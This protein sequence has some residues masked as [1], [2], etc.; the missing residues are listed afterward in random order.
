MNRFHLRSEN[1]MHIFRF[2]Y[3]MALHLEPRELYLNVLA[4][5]WTAR[6]V[7]QTIIRHEFPQAELPEM[8]ARAWT[9]EQVLAQFGISELTCTYLSEDCP[10]WNGFN[11]ENGIVGT[12]P[13]SPRLLPP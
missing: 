10:S 6:T 9:V 7:V 4:R 11:T 1:L 3:R 2:T 12:G 13:S 8:R 5:R